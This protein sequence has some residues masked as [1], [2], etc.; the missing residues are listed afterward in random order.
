MM[1]GFGRAEVYVAVSMMFGFGRAEV[2]VA[3]SMMP[4]QLC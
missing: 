2:Y 3:V 1:F 4:I